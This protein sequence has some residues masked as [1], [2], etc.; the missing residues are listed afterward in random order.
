M[1]SLGQHPSESELKDMMN[2]V[3]TGKK[4]K[5]TFA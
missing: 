5:I 2:D 3:D 1:K 4:G